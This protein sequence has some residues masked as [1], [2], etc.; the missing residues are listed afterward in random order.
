MDD[1]EPPPLELEEELLP[2][3]LLPEED[4]PEEDPEEPPPEELPLPLLAAAAAFFASAC[5][6]LI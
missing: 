2:E 3:E 5:S 6:F 1:P 4:P